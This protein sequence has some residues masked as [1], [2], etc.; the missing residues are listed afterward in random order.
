MLHAGISGIME[1]RQC[2]FGK[3]IQTLNCLTNLYLFMTLTSKFSSHSFN[4]KAL[5]G[6]VSYHFQ[7]QKQ[8][9]RPFLFPQHRTKGSSNADAS[10]DAGRQWSPES[11]RWLPGI[12]RKKSRPDEGV[13]E[14]H[15]RIFWVKHHWPSQ[16]CRV[17]K[18]K[19]L[20]RHSTWSGPPPTLPTQKSDLVVSG[21]GHIHHSPTFLI[22]VAWI[23]AWI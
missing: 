11:Y 2:S 22:L 10:V 8:G 23:Y 13:S 3:C 14:R 12:N 21:K 20:N 17:V 7:Q 6:T 18:T 4:S 9:E 19:T 16:I 15:Q 1:S 5:D